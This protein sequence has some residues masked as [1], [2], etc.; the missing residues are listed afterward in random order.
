MTREEAGGKITEITYDNS[1]RK[2]EVR[3]VSE[4]ALSIDKTRQK[5]KE[6]D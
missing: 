4:P 2:A 3:K 5:T 6:R 1:N